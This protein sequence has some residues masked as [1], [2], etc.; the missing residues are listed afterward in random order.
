M[1]IPCADVN[2]AGQTR[3]NGHSIDAP[4]AL[5]LVLHYLAS[6][7]HKIVLQEIFCCHAHIYQL[8]HH[9]QAQ[10]ISCYTVRDARCKN[11]LAER[12]R[13]STLQQPHM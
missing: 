9:L 1:P 4:T 8:L 7:V 3:L 5:V 10:D 6:T 11:I 2:L 12:R 13:V